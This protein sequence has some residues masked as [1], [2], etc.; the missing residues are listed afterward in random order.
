MR[1]L[2]MRI[3]FELVLGAVL[4]TSVIVYLRQSRR[5]LEDER[6][7]DTDAQTLRLLQEALR[8]KDLRMLSAVT[9]EE[10]P[11]DGNHA[12]MAKKEAVI[13]R[14]DRELAENRGAMLISSGPTFSRQRPKRQGRRERRGPLAK[15]AD[16]C[17][18]SIG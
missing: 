12:G 13:E 7:L 14:L 4:A 15:A 2:G 16:R 9:P 10:V 1:P 3:T 5:L 17:P 8:Q 11:A 6:R 18:G